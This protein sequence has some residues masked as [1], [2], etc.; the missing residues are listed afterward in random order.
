MFPQP[1]PR[2]PCCPTPSPFPSFPP[3]LSSLPFSLLSPPFFSP[4]FPPLP[5]FF[6]P[7]SSFL[8]FSFPPPFF[9]PFPPPP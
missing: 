8:L 5:F 7:P 3:F 6:P 9:P 2:S 4:S 1:S